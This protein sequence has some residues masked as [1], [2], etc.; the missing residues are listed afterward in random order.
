LSSSTEADFRFLE[1]I[2]GGARC[3]FLPIGV[4]VPDSPAVYAMFAE[5]IDA[6]RDLIGPRALATGSA[7]L[8]KMR[9]M[10]RY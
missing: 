5:F 10:P 4:P 3:A 8:V 6:P 7:K 2:T 1:N 9:L